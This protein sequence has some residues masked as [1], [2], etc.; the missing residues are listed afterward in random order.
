MLHIDTQRLLDSLQTLGQFGA[1]P[2]GGVNR[3]ALTDADQAARDWTVAQMRALDMQVQVDAIGNVIAT[4]AGSEDLP[5]VMMGSHIDTVRTGGLYD[6][7]LGVMAGLEVVRTLRQAGVRTRRPLAVAFFTNEEG[8]RFQPD[9]LG[10]LVYVGGLPLEQALQTRAVDGPLLGEELIRI[11]YDGAAQVGQ[12]AVDSYFELHI[13]QGPVL[14]QAGIQIGVVEGVQGIYWTRL[15]F[16][17]KSNHAGTTPMHLRRDAGMAAMRTAA[18]VHDLVQ[19]M[20]GGQLAT[21]G[22]LELEPNLVN[23]IA[24]EASMTV[25]LRNTDA[26]V[27]AAAR[28][29]LHAYAM[30]CATAHGVQLQTQVLAD[31]APVAF[32]AEMI[33]SIERHAKQA[34]LSTLRLPSGAGH[35]AQMLARICPAAMIFVPSVDGVSHNVHEYTPPADLGRGAQ[36]L[37]QAV[38]ERANR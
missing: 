35:D 4:Y 33:A 11:G 36:V 19:R 23:V 28:A 22:S 6:G 7:N 32:D 20:G 13:E 15:T 27:L 16:S 5:P 9:M 38:L 31:F 3:L 17:G 1:L 34:G 18:F 30:Q 14:D 12:P 26:Q 21:V 25:D 37:L 2:G 8:A 10:S 24:A 29:Q